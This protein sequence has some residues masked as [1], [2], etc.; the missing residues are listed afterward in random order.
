[1]KYR[2]KV[3]KPIKAEETDIGIGAVILLKYASR[4]IISLL[5]RK[6]TE[7][8]TCLIGDIDFLFSFN[9]VGRGV[10]D[11]LYR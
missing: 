4:Q 1:M 10:N 11:H 9:G 5:R 6:Y 3:L 8:K 2:V 7:D